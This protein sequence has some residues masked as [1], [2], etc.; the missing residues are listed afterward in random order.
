MEGVS[1]VSDTGQ[2]SSAVVVGTGLG[3]GRA[4]TLRT[5]D[6]VRGEVDGVAWAQFDDTKGRKFVGRTVLSLVVSRVEE[7]R[8]RSSALT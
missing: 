3:P 5:K 1:D 2:A 8:S 4:E 7:P 6:G